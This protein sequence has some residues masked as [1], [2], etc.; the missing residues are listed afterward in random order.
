MSA[1]EERVLTAALFTDHTAEDGWGYSVCCQ[2]VFH[3]ACLLAQAQPRQTDSATHAGPIDV[4]TDCPNCRGTINGS[5]RR[6]LCE[7]PRGDERPRRTLQGT[8]RDPRGPPM[9]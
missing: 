5:R 1:P 6:L 4:P 8:S 9:A 3:Y 7:G 2:Q